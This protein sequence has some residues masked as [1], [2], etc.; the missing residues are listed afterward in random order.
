MNG[1]WRTSSARA[2]KIPAMNLATLMLLT[3][4]GADPL[5]LPDSAWRDT[6]ALRQRVRAAEADL[7]PPPPNSLWGDGFGPDQRLASLDA[8]RAVSEQVTARVSSETHATESEEN[9]QGERTASV[10]VRVTSQ[11]DH[12]ELI[13]IHGVVERPGGWAARAVLHKDQAA[14][15][16][17][18]EVEADRERLRKLGPVLEEAIDKLDTA[19]LLSAEHS[20]ALILA[21]QLR[22][23]Q[24]LEILG[25]SDAAR[26]APEELA[27]AR[28]VAPVRQRSRIRLAVHGDVSPRLRQ[29]V[30]REVERMLKARGCLVLEAPHGP[31][32]PEVPTADA[33]LTIQSRDHREQGLDWRYV[34]FELSVVDARSQRPVF[35]YSGLPEFVHGGGPSL[36]RADE[37]VAR[38]LAE[39]LPEKAGAAFDGITCR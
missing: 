31:P 32:E 17:G 35:R 19:V 37:A 13:H 26:P 7:P 9:G 1:L 6:E 18:A 5:A 16:Y 25:R 36:E 34:G 24:I 29:A 15:V 4:C 3:G 28:K 14:E 22:R 12:A 33:T 23:G 38:R 30:Q 20:P 27:L 8:R 39:L 21:R 10:E 11:F 2:M